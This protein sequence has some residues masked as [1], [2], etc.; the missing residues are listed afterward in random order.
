MSFIN[1]IFLYALGAASLPI[2]YHLIKKM[3]TRTVPF[4]SLLFLKATPKEL[5]KRRRLRDMILLAIRTLMLLLLALAFARPFIQEDNIPF[6]SGESDKSVV[7]L[8]DNSFSMQ[9]RDYFDRAQQE[10][11]GILNDAGSDDQFAIVVFSDEARQVTDLSSDIAVHRTYINNSLSVSNKP[12]DIFKPMKLA[13]EILKDAANP[14]KQ[15]V[16]I[17]DFQENGWNSQFENWNIE[18]NITFVPVMIEDEDPS[19]DFIDAFNLKLDRNRNVVSTELA[20]RVGSYA[21]EPGD[22]QVRLI[23]NGMEVESK[24]A[25]ET[26]GKQVFFQ[27]SGLRSGKYQGE[28]RIGDDDLELDNVHYFNFEVEDQFPIVSING[29]AGVDF[30]L[31]NAFDLGEYSQ[32]RYNSTERFQYSDRRFSENKL[33]F[34]N[35]FQALS[36]QQLNTINEYVNNGG[37]LLISFGESVNT[38]RFSTNLQSLGVGAIAEKIVVRRIQRSDAIIGEVDLKHPIFSVFAEYGASDLFKPKFREYCRIEP[39]SN[40]VVLASFDTGD[41]FLIEKKSGKGRIL[42]YTSSFTTDWCDFPVN[43][44]FL[45]FLYQ[46]ANYSLASDRPRNEYL[47]GSIMAING[48]PDESW[49]IYGPGGLNFKVQLDETGSGFFRDTDVPGNYRVSNGTEDYNFSV[50]FDNIESILNTRGSEEA[51][52]MVVPSLN[53]SPEQVEVRMAGE[54]KIE[55]KKQKF[56]RYIIIL[57]LI[58]FMAESFLANRKLSLDK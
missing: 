5:V 50:N 38:G 11:E 45:P 40:A 22:K 23:L 53:E 13:E 3:R 58:L 30:F 37:T 19:N 55:E 16:L 12:T 39:D 1:P 47:I 26:Q 27:Q 31:K 4:S 28:I 46:I 33:V 52:S 15:I 48:A 57:I 17:S 56:W 2:I 51:Y 41:P 6:A 24:A 25:L 42:V 36:A 54:L 20:V 49:D 14:E 32:F 29:T 34:L 44:I 9:F 18:R 10:A 8:I 35:N 7:I 21:G 43:E